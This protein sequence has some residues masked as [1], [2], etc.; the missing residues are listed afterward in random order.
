MRKIASLPCYRVLFVQKGHQGTDP[1]L[2]QYPTHHF[3]LN[4]NFAR[5]NRKPKLL[6]VIYRSGSIGLWHVNVHGGHFKDYGQT[7]IDKII[8]GVCVS[9]VGVTDR[10]YFFPYE[11]TVH[12][13]NCLRHTL[14]GHYIVFRAQQLSF[15]AVFGAV[16]GAIVACIVI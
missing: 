13:I 6:E 2:P 5:N 16:D 14:Q 4:V 8:C 11:H 3:I 7:K 15:L 12:S 10:G 9:T 1:S